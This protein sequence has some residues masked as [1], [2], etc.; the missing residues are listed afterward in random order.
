MQAWIV[1]RPQSM[2]DMPGP[3]HAQV[4]QAGRC[5]GG[6]AGAAGQPD[7]GGGGCG[8]PYSDTSSQFWVQPDSTA[9]S[10]AYQPADSG[11]PCT[12]E[13][14]PVRMRSLVTW[15][16]CSYLSHCSPSSDARKQLKK[17][18]RHGRRRRGSEHASRFV[19]VLMLMTC[20]GGAGHRPPP[21]GSTERQPA[22]TSRL[23]AV[24]H[25]SL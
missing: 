9:C 8:Q 21:C 6:A 5:A 25:T 1:Q 7:S 13:C 10:S 14:V 18:L 3:H 16:S 22:A 17:G 20:R 4:Q 11:A 15:C 12:A 23:K 19:L 24:H 2:C